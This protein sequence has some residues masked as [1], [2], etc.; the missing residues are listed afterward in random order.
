MKNVRVLF[1]QD[2]PGVALAGEVKE[3][4]RG[5]AR[6]YLFPRGLATLAT[7]QELARIEKIK[8]QAEERRLKEQRDM[9]AL[10]RTLE[11][12]EVVVRARVAPSGE[13]YGSI[14]PG[15][16]AE[17]LS[18]LLDREVDRKMVELEGPVTKPG[19]YEFTVRLHPK[20]TA[21]MRLVAE[22]AE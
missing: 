4:R 6:N 14:G 10:A 2:V 19:E 18:K 22:A 1:L 3:V 21:K 9:E 12:R 11:G 20:V 13:Y 17:E 5:F 7:P 8:R 15:D 16:I